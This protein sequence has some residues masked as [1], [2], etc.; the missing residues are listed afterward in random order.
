MVLVVQLSKRI[1]VAFLGEYHPGLL[2]GVVHAATSWEL[3]ESLPEHRQP[4]ALS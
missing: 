2:A 4:L 1:D 3:E